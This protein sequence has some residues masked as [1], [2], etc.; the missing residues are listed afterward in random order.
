MGHKVR[1]HLVPNPF[2]RAHPW[3]SAHPLP[4]PVLSLQGPPESSTQALLVLRRPLV[5]TGSKNNCQPF[6][7]PPSPVPGAEMR[8]PGYLPGLLRSSPP[9]KHSEMP[10]R[11]GIFLSLSPRA[12][13]PPYPPHYFESN[14]MSQDWIS[15]NQPPLI[16]KTWL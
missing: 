8:D 12:C 14:T 10:Y 5:A 15:I 13:T 6:L 11:E 9:T 4:S 1:G 2:L 16:H 7:L 3:H